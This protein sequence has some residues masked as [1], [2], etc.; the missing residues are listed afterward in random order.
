MKESEIKE[1]YKQHNMKHIHTF[2]KFS[3]ENL[4]EAE[5]LTPLES[6]SFSDIEDFQELLSG[7]IEDITNRQKNGSLG[8]EDPRTT[9][10]ESI[11]DL[12]RTIRYWLI[13]NSKVFKRRLNLK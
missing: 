10:L 11:K 4:T 3:D 6:M 8:Y 1:E 7:R 9:Y 2:K 5:N 13:D 12:H